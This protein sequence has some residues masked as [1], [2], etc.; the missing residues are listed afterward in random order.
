MGESLGRRLARRIVGEIDAYGGRFTKLN[1]A[2]DLAEYLARPLERDD[3]ELLTE[4]LLGEGRDL[5]ETVERLVCRS[6]ARRSGHA[7]A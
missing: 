4:P 1:G 6:T 5:V 2:A 7:C 3:E